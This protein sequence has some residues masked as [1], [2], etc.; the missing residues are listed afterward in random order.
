MHKSLSTLTGFIFLLL[1][2]RGNWRQGGKATSTAQAT[3][4]PTGVSKT[5]CSSGRC[6]LLVFLQRGLGPGLPQRV[7]VLAQPGREAALVSAAESS[8]STGSREMGKRDAGCSPKCAQEGA[9]G[10]AGAGV[11]HFGQTPNFVVLT[12]KT[13]L[14][15]WG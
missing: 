12:I 15:L 7:R 5:T 3:G 11:R 9:S 2:G 4:T 6:P 10:R 1:W 13:L 8:F 14:P